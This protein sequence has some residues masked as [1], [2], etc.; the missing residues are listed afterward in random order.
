MCSLLRH[1]TFKAEHRL[2]IISS[3]WYAH[4]S[5]P[6][7]EDDRSPFVAPGENISLKVDKQATV[8]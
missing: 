3:V 8:Y 1:E 5:S 4:T 7:E 2:S 6:C